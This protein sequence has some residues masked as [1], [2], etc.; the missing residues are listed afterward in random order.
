MMN[1]L[2]IGDNHLKESIRKQYTSLGVQ[3]ITECS[4]DIL[5]VLSLE[6]VDEIVVLSE[7]RDEDS[8]ACD[9]RAMD[10]LKKMAREWH[11]QQEDC[12]DRR[13]IVHLMLQSQTT[14]WMLQTMDLPDDV[15]EKFEVYPFTI[16]DVWAKNVLVQMPGIVNTEYPTLDHGVT[17]KDDHCVVHNNIGIGKD[18]RNFVH[19]V[20]SGFNTQAEAVAIH[21]ALVA[22][23]PNYNP[24]QKTPLR[25]RITIVEEGIKTKRDTFI[26]KYRHLFDNS[27]YRTI[28]LKERKVAFHRPMYDGRRT[29]FV[30]VEWE[31]V[32]AAVTHPEVVNKIGKWASDGHQLLTFFVCHDDD[33][34]NLAESMSLP[35]VIYESRKHGETCSR[36]IPVMV[37][38]SHKG[39]ADAFTRSATYRNL[40]PFG[41]KDCGYDVTLPLVRLARLLKYFYDCSYGNVGVPTELPSNEVEEAW[42]CE[43]S[44]KMR[45]SNI[46][47]V[48]TIA[49]K[50]RSLGHDAEDADTFYALTQAEIETL[51]EVE[52]N[53]WSVERLIMGSRPCSD[54]EMKDIRTDVK[55]K[56]KAY[57]KRDI[58]F[59]LRA[60]SE[61]EEDGT[62]KNARV[63]D[64]DLTACIPM[65]VKTFYDE[66][67]HGIK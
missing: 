4:Y 26:A 12:R 22:H 51:A 43:K 44:F 1:I 39:L 27:F 14:L 61:L 32:D 33:E 6:D 25:T 23:Y 15:N 38:Q 8:V 37:Q 65:M 64:Y 18:S 42:R 56:K 46:Y 49:T 35:M 31:F 16:E 55:S 57:K 29:D 66:N 52:H 9:N 67:E 2:L 58:H 48:M 62:G 24:S 47:N 50:M 63:Y 20:I 11:P 28:D 7:A 41:M 19:V 5:D 21:T 60:Y 40:K 3:G 36:E 59:D 10:V 34:R 30:D 17:H 54:Q 53:R 45:F 13:P